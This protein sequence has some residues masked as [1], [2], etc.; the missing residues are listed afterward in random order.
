MAGLDGLASGSNWFVNSQEAA[1]QRWQSLC[2]FLLL[3]LGCQQGLSA[4]AGFV[5]LWSLQLIARTIVNQGQA[6]GSRQ[7][8]CGGAVALQTRWLLQALRSSQLLLSSVFCFYSVV[9]NPLKLKTNTSL[10][11][12]LGPQRRLVLLCSPSN[13]SAL[14]FLSMYR[15][16]KNT[17][18]MD[19]QLEGE[20]KW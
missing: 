15:H 9:F 13:W 6:D 14:I 10:N 3:V 5:K 16:C 18:L 4:W 19:T 12:E 7:Y 2:C 8:F 17:Q 11:A 20:K 1:D